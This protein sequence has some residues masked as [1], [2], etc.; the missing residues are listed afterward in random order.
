MRKNARY[1][2]QS[3]EHTAQTLTCSL[4]KLTH[5]TWT[6]TKSKHL[7]AP[8]SVCQG[9]KAATITMF[10]PINPSLS[11]VLH[12]GQ[13]KVIAATHG[14]TLQTPF[15]GCIQ[16]V[17]EWITATD[18]IRVHSYSRTNTQDGRSITR[19]RPATRHQ[20]SST[21]RHLVGQLLHSCLAELDQPYG[22]C[23]LRARSGQ[24]ATVSVKHAH[25]SLLPERGTARDTAR[26]GRTE[27]LVNRTGR[28]GLKQKTGTP[29][30]C[31]IGQSMV[32][33][34]LIRVTN[35]RTDGR[36]ASRCRCLSRLTGC[37]VFRPWLANFSSVDSAMLA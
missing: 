23:L 8:A 24:P 27:K 10:E 2:S 4:T 19:G 14:R 5:Y 11:S 35:A 12:N 18:R 15:D 3:R 21:F 1:T 7:Q 33:R 28:V 25:G 36:E 13:A 29:K 16:F 9:D 31:S 32:R 20:Q 6:P 17:K 22:V 37:V 34:A 30:A 26:R